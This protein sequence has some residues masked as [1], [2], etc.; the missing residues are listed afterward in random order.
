MNEISQEANKQCKI[1]SNMHVMFNNL[2]RVGL[3][4]TEETQE[5]D[6]IVEAGEVVVTAEPL[7][8]PS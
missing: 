4:T 5:E 6:K 7:E 1:L 3:S 2:R 8:F